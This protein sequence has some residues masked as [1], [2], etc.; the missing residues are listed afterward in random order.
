MRYV[1]IALALVALAS[2][3]MSEEMNTKNVTYIEEKSVFIATNNT[4][5]ET[6]TTITQNYTWP[7]S[8]GLSDYPIKTPK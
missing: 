3:A 7:A 1:Y 5:I 6:I 4:T 8:W 2:L